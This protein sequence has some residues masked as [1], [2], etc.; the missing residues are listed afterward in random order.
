VQHKQ[1]RGHDKHGRKKVSSPFQQDPLEN[2]DDD[3]AEA[4][5]SL[6][7]MRALLSHQAEMSYA[8]APTN[9][10][11]NENESSDGGT[12][13]KE[14]LEATSETNTEVEPGVSQV[15]RQSPSLEI[16]G[17]ISSFDVS[18]LRSDLPD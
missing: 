11:I 3:E 7:S 2:F 6:D 8:K 1:I 15:S 18:Q 16:P 10:E 13:I 9:V 14:N 5:S 17:S 12:E 4:P